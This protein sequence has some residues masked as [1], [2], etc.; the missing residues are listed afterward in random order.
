MAVDVS[1]ISQI[2]AG[3]GALVAGVGLG[4]GK[5]TKGKSHTHPELVKEIQKVSEATS[6]VANDVKWLRERAEENA[7]AQKEEQLFAQVLSK[8]SQ[9]EKK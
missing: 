3:T 6:I 8:L 9:L 1:I 4:I 5:L 7:R 2:V